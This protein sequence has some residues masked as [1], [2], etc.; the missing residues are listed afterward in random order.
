MGLCGLPYILFLKQGLVMYPHW[1]R[2]QKDPPD[3]ASLGAEVY[4]NVSPG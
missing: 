1:P 3:S 2:T 4:T